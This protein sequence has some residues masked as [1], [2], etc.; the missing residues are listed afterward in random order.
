MTYLFSFIVFVCQVL[1]VAVF[2]RAMLSWFS[3]R[4]NTLTLLL[5]KVTDP[6]L[7]P[8]RRIMPG[9]GMFDFSPLIAIIL[10]QLIARL[11]S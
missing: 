7:A 10:L 1:T 6:I 8:I 2:L 5:D 3:Q 9:T 11:L 4:P